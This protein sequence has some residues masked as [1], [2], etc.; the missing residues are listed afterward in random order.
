MEVPPALRLALRFTVE[1]PSRASGEVS[2]LAG[3]EGNQ[4]LGTVMIS[5]EE[6]P[7]KFAD[8]L[9]SRM[10]YVDEGEGDTVVFLLG[11]SMSSYIWRNII[12]HVSKLAR[13]IAPETRPSRSARS[14]FVL[15]I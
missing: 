14:R 5:V 15:K 2:E 7:K 13:C 9:G 8:I 10:A 1:P 12:P 6:Q 11:N 4:G 3:N